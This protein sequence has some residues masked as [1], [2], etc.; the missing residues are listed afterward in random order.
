MLTGV[1]IIDLTQPLGPATPPWPIGGR[2]LEATVTA[3]YE[4]GGAYARRIT[5][6]EHI[7]TH[8][9]APAHFAPDGDRVEAVGAEQ[10][11]R[12]AVVVDVRAAC[13]ADPDHHVPAAT[14]EAW[15]AGHGRIEP[16]TAVLVMTGWDKLRGDPDRYLTSLHFPGLAT[17]A[18]RLLVDRQVAGIGIDTLGIDPGCEPDCPVHHITLPAGLWHLEGLL[19]LDELPPTGAWIVVGAARIQDASGAPAR[20]IALVP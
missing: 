7:G 12:P 17:D 8:F 20:V 5:F 10:L 13:A 3:T 18:G 9:D 11:V 2:P 14:F 19:Q 1:R 4:D 6:D 16:G 15:E